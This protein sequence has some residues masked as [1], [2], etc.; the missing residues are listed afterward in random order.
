[1]SIFYRFR[2]RARS[3][4]LGG[5]G[6]YEHVIFNDYVASL[7]M[8]QGNSIVPVVL[9]RLFP[10]PCLVG[11]RTTVELFDG[12]NRNILNRRIIVAQISSI[13]FNTLHGPFTSQPFLWTSTDP[14][15]LRFTLLIGPLLV[16][17]TASFSKPLRKLPQKPTGQRRGGASG[18][19]LPYQNLVIQTRRRL[20][21]PRSTSTCVPTFTYGKDAPGQDGYY[22]GYYQ[23]LTD[24]S[25]QRT[26][27]VMRSSLRTLI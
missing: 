21:P 9:V 23:Y 13:I 7:R 11:S 22:A 8:Y 27:L 18:S 3:P 5:E 26:E 25:H 12:D 15:S 2:I 16:G 4:A 6:W 19:I 10:D 20:I 14:Y 24:A 17:S 1:M